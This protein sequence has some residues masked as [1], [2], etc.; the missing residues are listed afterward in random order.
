MKSILLSIAIAT[1]I[2]I[3]VV[4]KVASIKT[5]APQLQTSTTRAIAELEAAQK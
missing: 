5:D 3:A 1:P 4:P 2:L